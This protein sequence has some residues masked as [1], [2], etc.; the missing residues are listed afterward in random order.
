M[1][2]ARRQGSG[3]RHQ[4]VPLAPA[5]PT[6]AEP[7]GR[8]LIPDTVRLTPL[9]LVLPGGDLLRNVNV[10]TAIAAALLVLAVILVIKI[11]KAL[12]FAAMFGALAGGVSL[13]QGSP[14]ALA[15]THAAIG[16]G[17]AAATLFLVKLT[18]S[19]VLWLLITA[20]GVA[21]LFLYD[22]FRQ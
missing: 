10:P 11:G 14:P 12:L 2:S 15:G 9:L 21:A 1:V 7:P 18:K 13:G 6:G 20:L 8:S 16:F 3:I 17:V 5:L 4:G 22:G 19:I